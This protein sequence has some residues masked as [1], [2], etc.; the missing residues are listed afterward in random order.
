MGANPTYAG[1]ESRPRAALDW[2]F[3]DLWRKG[4]SVVGGEAALAQQ[5]HRGLFWEDREDEVDHQGAEV[6]RA[7]APEV[8]SHWLRDLLKDG[9]V[10]LQK[11]VGKQV[12][13]EEQRGG[14]L[15][16]GRD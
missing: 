15:R 12:V 16:E 11:V 3:G 7:A 6:G 2:Q 4:Q 10:L 5:D 8:A 9:E 14:A 1:G 13:L